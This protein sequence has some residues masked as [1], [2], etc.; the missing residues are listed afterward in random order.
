MKLNSISSLT[1]CVPNFKQDYFVFYLSFIIICILNIYTNKFFRIFF[2]LIKYF[3]KTL[4][5]Q[6]KKYK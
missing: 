1:N 5:L 2:K 4:L 6:S 3:E